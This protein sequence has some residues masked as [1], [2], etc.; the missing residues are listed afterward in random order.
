V[1]VQRGRESIARV[2]IF[3]PMQACV[4]ELVMADFTFSFLAIANWAGVCLTFLPVVTMRTS[5]AVIEV[6][7]SSILQA[8]LTADGMSA[9][10][11]FQAVSVT[12]R[13]EGVDLGLVLIGYFV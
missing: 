12:V 5:L 3:S 4:T 11:A 7:L 6:E 1:T 8:G 2:T 13:A 10:L 9:G